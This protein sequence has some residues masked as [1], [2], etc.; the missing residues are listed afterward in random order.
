MEDLSGFIY[1]LQLREFIKTKEEIY[2]IGM[3]KDISK[4][5]LQYPKGTQ[6]HM[7]LFTENVQVCERFLIN[8][9][10]QDFKG[11]LDIGREYFEGDRTTMIETIYNYIQNNPMHLNAKIQQQIK[12]V[13]GFRFICKR[14]GYVSNVK[15]N[16][17]KHLENI[18][19]CKPINA[20]IDRELLISEL[21][22]EVKDKQDIETNFICKRC[23]Y[24]SKVK[25]NMIK[26]LNTKKTCKPVHCDIDRKQ[27]ISDLKI[28][29]PKKMKD[30][31]E[32]IVDSMKV[33]NLY[34]PAIKDKVINI[35]ISNFGQELVNLDPEMLIDCL[36]EMDI[37]PLFIKL[38]F[39]KAH[40]ENCNMRC[41]NIKDKLFEY[42]E[43][44]RWI[45]TTSDIVLHRCIR[46]CV[47]MI[48]T[49]YEDNKEEIDIDIDEDHYDLN[50]IIGWLN[51]IAM[52]DKALYKGIKN[53][54]FLH[55]ISEKKKR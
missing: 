47:V 18:K 48:Q 16:M 34:K 49:F 30:L 9:F 3:T 10:R 20:N 23:G 12:K 6:L 2:K 53:T 52:E 32:T 33:L 41:R 28:H 50:Q 29:A 25:A 26:H 5:I 21:K 42:W 8:K 35:Q 19:E 24:V 17:I 37:M 13:F 36:K 27:L 22:E 15:A 55:V 11:R 43:E 45:V 31:E 38:H 51:A 54:M 46:Q 1:I 39:N 40:P 7:A 44:G 14:C 4:R